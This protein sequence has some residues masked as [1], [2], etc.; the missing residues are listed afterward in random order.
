MN[1]INYW[2]RFLV[3]GKV[4]DFLS[5]KKAQQDVKSGIAE[6]DAKEDKSGG[7]S[8]AGVYRDYGNG[9]KG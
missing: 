5:Y 7:H 8:H 9:F 6:S 1:E 4:D 3:T 2:D